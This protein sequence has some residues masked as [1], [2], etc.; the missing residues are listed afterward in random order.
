MKVQLLDN[1]S[2]VIH[3][4]EVMMTVVPE[5]IRWKGVVYSHHFT[6]CPRGISQYKVAIIFDVPPELP[7]NLVR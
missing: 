7:E 3:Q 4:Q 2:R 5:L 6:H 1:L